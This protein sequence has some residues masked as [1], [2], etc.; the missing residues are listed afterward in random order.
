MADN[1]IRPVIR[2]CMMNADCEDV[3]CSSNAKSS[4]FH[5]GPVSSVVLSWGMSSSET[6]TNLNMKFQKLWLKFVTQAKHFIRIIDLYNELKVQ[7]CGSI[8]R[9]DITW[10]GQLHQLVQLEL[11]D[12]RSQCY[13]NFPPWYS[14]HE[15]SWNHVD[16]ML[17]A[18]NASTEEIVCSCKHPFLQASALAKHQCTCQKYKKCLSS[19]LEM[20]KSVWKGKRQRWWYA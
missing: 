20:A 16:S 5:A 1:I 2:I 9:H 17:Q 10:W 12:S 8:W 6:S 18:G 14:S 13:L 19:A 11:E 3:G 7:S 4:F 15:L